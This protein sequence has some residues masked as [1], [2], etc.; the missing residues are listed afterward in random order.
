MLD[1]KQ[2][3]SFEYE[4]KTIE[5]KADFRFFKRLNELTG[6]V[7]EIINEF[8]MNEDKRIEYLPY[9]IKC[10]TDEELDLLKLQNDIY[11]LEIPIVSNLINIV[12]F[13]I[14]TEMTL[15]I[16]DSNEENEI[17]NDTE[18][19][20]K[21]K[22]FQEWWN[23]YYFISTRILRMSYNEF[24]DST[25]RVVGS[26]NNLN[27]RYYENIL[28]KTYLDVMGNGS[29]NSKNQHEKVKSNKVKSLLDL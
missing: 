19:G 5:L 4:N 23:T 12:F 13:I 18:D 11:S 29:N 17:E 16:N 7:F 21:D 25:P 26:L 3:E 10:M 15:E 8:L 6:N 24:L 22:E 1:V 9:L 28:I 27:I 20:D 2:I 14:A